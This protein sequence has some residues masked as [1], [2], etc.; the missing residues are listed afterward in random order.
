MLILPIKG[1]VR[2]TQHFGARPEVYKQF[3]LRGHN[4]LDFTG[5]Q[6]GELVPIIAPFE[7][8]VTEVGDQGNGGYGKFVRIRS[9][10]LDS[11]RYYKET[12][13]AHLSQINVQRNQ[14]V[15][16][17]EQVGIMGNTGFSTAPHLHW[18]VRFLNRWR[19]VLNWDNGFK[20]YVDIE[21]YL[22]YC[23]DTFKNRSVKDFSQGN[24]VA[25]PYG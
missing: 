24:N 12:V 7:G 8:V 3:G 20:G 23:E 13:L 2:L 1:R 16:M 11:A 18:G 19:R 9:T 21:Q 5:E 17:G 4:G 25:Y 10:G 6:K 14:F 22:L 15:F